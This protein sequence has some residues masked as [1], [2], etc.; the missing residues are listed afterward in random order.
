MK[1]GLFCLV[2]NYDTSVNEAIFEQIRQVVYAE[3]L[4][5]DE[6][7]FGEHHFNGFSV[8]PDPSLLMAYAAAKTDRIKLG[9]AGFLAPFYNPIRLSESIN[10]LEH[11]SV[12]RI[13]AGFAKGGFAADSK[14]FL[15]S[16][17]ELR[18]MMFES[19]EAVDALV[20]QNLSLY[21][22][23]YIDFDGVDLHPKPLREKIPFYIATF[24]SPVTVEFAARHGYGLMFSQGATV[25]ECVEMQ[26]LY[27]EIAGSYPETVILRVFCVA[28][29][30]EAAVDIA[31]PAID[32]FIKSMR[33]ASA[34]SMK[35]VWDEENYKKLLEQRYEFFAGENFLLNGIIGTQEDCIAKIK[36]ID[37]EVKNVHLILKP[38]TADFGE[39]KIM[40]NTF[41]S[42]IR[43]HI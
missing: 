40:L 34:Q 29:T 35:P 13:N 15:K 42:K 14:H 16:S 23:K 27:K 38:A 33:A 22:G 19:V 32:H 2:E 39:S 31:K 21:H 9:T 20:N 6:V 28:D 3:Q 36:E 30:K 43:P 24:S 7:W 10:V 26:K 41:N 25:Q 1:V 12:G 4:G 37:R 5:F 8:I 18:D 11:L 17:D